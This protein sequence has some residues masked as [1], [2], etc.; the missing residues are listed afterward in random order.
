MQ[1]PRIPPPRPGLG[2][3]P[4]PGSRAKSPLR[5]EPRPPWQL[6]AVGLDLQY[7]SFGSLEERGGGWGGPVCSQPSYRTTASFRPWSPD[8]PY[9]SLAPGA[10]GPGGRRY[11]SSCA[12]GPPVGATRNQQEA[13]QPHWAR[14]TRVPG[15]SFGDGVR[16]FVGIF[17]LFCY[18]CALLS[19]WLGISER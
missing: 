6:L 4:S 17:F 8:R 15:T 18:P 13:G 3:P 9:M 10:P 11:S 16:D 14:L 2:C 5:T 19:T 12:R 1:L 7:I